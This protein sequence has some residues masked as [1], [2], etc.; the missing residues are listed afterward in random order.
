MCVIGREGNCRDGNENE[1][2]DGSRPRGLEMMILLGGKYD[3]PRSLEDV[4]VRS[5]SS[6]MWECETPLFCSVEV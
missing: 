5:T 1:D 2:G 6:D 3:E 4:G